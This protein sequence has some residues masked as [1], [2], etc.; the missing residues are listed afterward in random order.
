VRSQ[1]DLCIAAAAIANLWTVSPWKRITSGDKARP[2][3]LR[4][5]TVIRFQGAAYRPTE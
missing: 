2:G 5:A 1:A 3:T 4:G